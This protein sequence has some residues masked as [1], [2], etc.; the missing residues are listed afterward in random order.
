MTSSEQRGRKT[1]AQEITADTIQW[2]ARLPAD[3]RPT[4]LREFPHVLNKLATLWADDEACGT[5][6]ESLMLDDRGGRQGFPPAA[7]SELIA[8]NLHHHGSISSPG[9]RPAQEVDV[10]KY[11]TVQFT[12]DDT[13]R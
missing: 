5:Y 7:L 12:W 2:L 4:A 3:L 6:L 11:E 1:N 8:L 13:E 10:P 9:Q